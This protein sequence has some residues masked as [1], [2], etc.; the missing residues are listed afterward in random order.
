MESLISIRQ[1]CAGGQ[2]NYEF[3]WVLKAG[4]YSLYWGYVCADASTSEDSSNEVAAAALLT[5]VCV[6]TILVSYGTTT[7]VQVMT[8]PG[9]R[10]CER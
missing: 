9:E 5:E 3:S 2:D 6:P 4:M 7:P 10:A 1:I 8:P